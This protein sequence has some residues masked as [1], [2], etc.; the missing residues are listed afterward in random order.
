MALDVGDG[1]PDFNLEG[2]LGPINF[3]DK[4]KGTSAKFLVI[5]F[6]PRDNTPGCTRQ[7]EGFQAE[8]AAFSKYGAE[9]IG[10]SRDSIKSHG[11]F[12]QKFELTFALGSD[13]DGGVCNDFGVW[14]EKK[15]YGR[16]YMG[17]ERSTFLIDKKGAIAGVW[18]K[19]KV[20]GHVEEVLATLKD[21]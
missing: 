18:R 9:I 14:V 11:N 13:I 10:I 2:D 3:Q 7:A 6:Y 20:N 17:I 19:V 4:L 8:L 21:L 5:Y 16:T 15:N 12:R 1:C